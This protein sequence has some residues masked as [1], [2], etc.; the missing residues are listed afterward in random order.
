MLYAQTE[1]REYQGIASFLYEVQ[2][3]AFYLLSH[4]ALLPQQALTIKVG[5]SFLTLFQ[6]QLT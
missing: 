5:A 3:K 4:I 1:G 6:E 2:D